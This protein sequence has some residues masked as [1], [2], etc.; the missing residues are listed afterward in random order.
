VTKDARFLRYYEQELRFVRDLAGEFASEHAR[1]A[2]RF[3]LDADTCADPHVEWLLDGCAFL[4]ARVQH[5]LDGDYAVF[6]QH[7]LEMVYPDYLAP[8]PAAGIVA[9]EPGPD[10]APLEN[11]FTVPRGSRLQSRIVPGEASRCVFTTAHPVTVWPVEVAEARYLTAAAVASLG[12]AGAGRGRAQA[13]VLLKLRARRGAR[14]SGLALDRLVLHLAGRDRVAHLLYEALVGHARGLAGRPEDRPD[15]ALALPGGRVSR[16]G[17]GEDEAL[18][19]PSPRGFSGFRLLREYFTLP[20]RFLFAALDGLR[21]LVRR[22]GN[23]GVEVVVLLDRFEPALDGA[24]TKDQFA[25]FA[26]PALNLFPRRAKPI[27]VEPHEE[28]HHVV[29][30]RARP[31][32]HEVFAVTRA[33]GFGVDGQEVCA[34][35]PFYAVGARE[36]AAGAGAYYTVERRPRLVGEREHRS[37][38]ARSAYLGGEVWLELC[39]AEGGPLDRRLARLD[40]D[41]LASNRDLPLRLPLPPGEIHFSVEP[42]G[43]LAGAR[44]LGP[45]TRPRP[46]PAATE[47]EGGGVWGDVAW[48]LVGHLALNYH[49]LVDGAGDRGAD[50]LR[51]L[52]ELYAAGAEPQLARHADAVRHVSSRTVTGRLPG[53]G[54]IAF[55]RGLEVSVELAEAAFQNGSAFVLGGVLESF[56]RR[57]VALN[58]FVETVVR[59]SERGEVMRWP[60]HIGSRHLA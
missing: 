47:P 21:P 41:V 22:A 14:L 20:D 32:D 3:G 34:F 43:P 39:D 12:F 18:F 29:V 54:P 1:I 30:D 33:A 19:P 42:A 13:G 55:G 59:T 5:K 7:L 8:T 40:V 48:R 28:Q 38:P 26:T 2:N 27:Q 50:A 17:F 15:D 11:G 16:V 25:L 52:L 46:S 60:S 44:A 9:I 37:R 49:S 6:T 36:P 58:S 53:G 51:G 10:A 4:A 56:F 24:V 23:G 45:F 35:S 57:H 31:L